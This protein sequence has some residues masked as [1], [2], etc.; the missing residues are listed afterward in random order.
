MVW[1][2]VEPYSKDRFIKFHSVQS[3]GLAVVSMGIYIVLGM[4]PILGW[5]LL[6]FAPL[7]FFVV[8]VICA[9]KAF[10]KEKFKLPVIGDFAEKQAAA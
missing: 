1:L 9:V 6:L 4:I 8:W 3:L 2:L 7:A 10:Q 5:I